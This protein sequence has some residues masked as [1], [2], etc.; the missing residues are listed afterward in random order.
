MKKVVGAILLAVVIAAV[1][2]GLIFVFSPAAEED[3]GTGPGTLQNSPAA[4]E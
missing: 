3:Q 4:E 2:V 1:V